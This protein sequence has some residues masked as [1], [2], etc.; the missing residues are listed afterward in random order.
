[1]RKKNAFPVQ[2]FKTW[3]N[4]Q[5]QQAP[6]IASDEFKKGL[7]MALEHVLKTCNYDVEFS[8]NYWTEQGLIE[9]QQAGSPTGENLKQ[10]FVVGPSGQEYNRTYQ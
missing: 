4:T 10:Q 8:Y 7:C 6:E 2:D 1:M 9:F 5:L 3:V